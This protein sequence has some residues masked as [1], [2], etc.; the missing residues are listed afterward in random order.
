MGTMTFLKRTN[1]PIPIKLSQQSYR[2]TFGFTRIL[3]ADKKRL[4]RK[5]ME[6]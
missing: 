1:L 2:L 5:A 4:K 3:G 6:L